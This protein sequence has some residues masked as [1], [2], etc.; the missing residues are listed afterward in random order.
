MK[1]VIK[2]RIQEVSEL[3]H[4]SQDTLRYYEK[5]G[6]ID[7][8]TRG[9]GGIRNYQEKDIQRLEFVSCMRDAGVSIQAL[10]KYIQLSK[11]GDCTIEERKQILVQERDELIKK[12]EMIQRSLKKLNYKIDNYER[13]LQSKKI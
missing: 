5:I 12:Q 6:L 7:R 8:V 10:Q 4:L 1:E 13:I 11:E 2:M 3:F 9:P